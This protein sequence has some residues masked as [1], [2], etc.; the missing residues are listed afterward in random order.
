MPVLIALCMTAKNPGT[1]YIYID[2]IIYL[3][4]SKAEYIS[5][6]NV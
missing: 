6:P 1:V 5:S 2:V 3:G 4:L